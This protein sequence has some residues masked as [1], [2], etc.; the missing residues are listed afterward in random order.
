MIN[1]IRTFSF[2]LCALMLSLFVIGCGKKPSSLDPPEGT[3]DPEYPRQYP[4]PL[5]PEGKQ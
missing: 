3:H 4:A 2:I 1:L 5:P